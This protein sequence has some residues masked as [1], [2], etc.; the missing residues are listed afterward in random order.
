[1]VVIGTLQQ[2]ICL[3][4]NDLG[5]CSTTYAKIEM[6]ITIHQADKFGSYWAMQSFAIICEWH[7]CHKDLNNP[8]KDF[9]A[10][11]RSLSLP[12]TSIQIDQFKTS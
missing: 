12:I 6:S 2:R 4:T 11:C 3:Y 9:T 7:H 5:L 10:Y 1:V 8:C